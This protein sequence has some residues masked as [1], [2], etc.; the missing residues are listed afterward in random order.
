MEFT[1]IKIGTEN[2]TDAGYRFIGKP[3]ASPELERLLGE[4]RISRDIDSLFDGFEGVYL[5]SDGKTYSVLFYRGTL[6]PHE[7]PEVW[8]EVVKA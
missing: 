1:E 5:G 7:E 3:A 4:N 8:C 2:L 6:L